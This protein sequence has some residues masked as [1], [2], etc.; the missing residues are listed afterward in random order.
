MQITDLI[1]YPVKGAR[2][3]SLQQASIGPMGLQG[4]RIFTLLFEGKLANQ[5]QVPKLV[6]IQPT[7]L[8]DGSLSLSHDGMQD[9]TLTPS[10]MGKHKSVDIYSQQVPIIDQGEDVAK[11]FSAATGQDVRLVMMAEAVDWFLPLPEF[12]SVHGQKQAKF[13]DAAPILLTNQNSLKD[14]NERLTIDVP[15]ERF[16]ANIVVSGLAAYEEDQQQNY[17]AA[18]VLLTR[19]TV[20]ERCIVTTMDQQDGTM[21]K[22]PLKTLSKY[23]KRANDYAG[24][25][26]FGSYLTTQD[27]GRLNVGDIFHNS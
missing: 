1:I 15:M 21:K 24:G 9:F 22:E 17:R 3:C 19:V 4:D 10:P 16:R 8:S 23:R 13:V 27:A 18:D 6:E 14:L 12:A 7:W 11:W 25:I 5:K 20:C 26:V 2:G